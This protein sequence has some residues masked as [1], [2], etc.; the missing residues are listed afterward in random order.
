MPNPVLFIGNKRYSSW[1]LRP[2]LVLKHAGIAFDEVVVQLDTPEFA[3]RI[4]P[5]SPSR[6]VPVLHADGQIVWDSLA[7]A[8]WAAER[9]PALWPSD[10]KLRAT[11]RSQAAT[12][13]SGFAN[14][15]REAPMNLKRQGKA[16]T[17]SDA[18][19]RDVAL[20]EKL[21]RDFRVAGGPFFFGAWS[22]TD[23]F[24]TPVATRIA[25]YAI[26]VEPQARAYVDA[27]LSEPHYQAWRAA[28][29]EETYPN[30]MNDDF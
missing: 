14:L 29:L 20:V 8:E 23:A 6:T 21:W 26:P 25:S 30:P 9:A 28:A 1:S 3:E 19:R 15:R 7:I 11:A 18:A 16:K 2:W 4:A 12:M 5:L 24:W 22:I 10:P 27:L 13:H 17:L